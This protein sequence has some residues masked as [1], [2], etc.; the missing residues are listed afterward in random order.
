[1]SSL[2][3]EDEISRAKEHVKGRMV[4]GLE[5][6]AARMARIARGIMFDVPLYSLDEMLERVDAVRTD[7]H[8]RFLNAAEAANLSCPELT[9]SFKRQA[10]QAVRLRSV[11]AGPTP[12]PI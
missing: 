5:A 9:Q 6:T 8:S 10:F 12:P 2:I 4:L 3:T 7:D 1:M 11:L